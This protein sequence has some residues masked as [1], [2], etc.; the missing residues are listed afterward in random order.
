MF[1][2]YLAARVQWA[3]L[4]VGVAVEP[5]APIK[6]GYSRNPAGRLEQ[7]RNGVPFNLMLVGVVQGFGTAEEAEMAEA[8][9]LMEAARMF[10]RTRGEW[11]EAD[12]MDAW[13]KLFVP[14]E[15]RLL[16]TRMAV[17]LDRAPT[18]RSPSVIG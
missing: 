1:E 15:G 6:I 17:D 18:C 14:A 8:V 7:L 3:Q 4:M 16:N 10:K 5:C 13:A 9:L 2:V 11:F 12:P